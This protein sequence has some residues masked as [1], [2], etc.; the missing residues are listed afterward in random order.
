MNK[1]KYDLGVHEIKPYESS[2]PRMYPVLCKY[3]LSY[4]VD[5]GGRVIL[6]SQLVDGDPEYDT[7]TERLG[8]ARRRALLGTQHPSL[9]TAYILYL[10][11]RVEN[12]ENKLQDCEINLQEWVEMYDQAD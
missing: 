1:I 7:K 9:T 8:E 10:E 6:E 5:Q 12:L 3:A 4:S 2:I 11:K